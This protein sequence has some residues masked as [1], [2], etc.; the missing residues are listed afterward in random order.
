MGQRLSHCLDAAVETAASRQRCHLWGKRWRSVS[1]GAV[2]LA[3][4]LR[5]PRNAC[6]D[7]PPTKTHDHEGKIY[8][9]LSIS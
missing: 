1:W 6:T 4:S 5:D 3:D 2:V 9:F 7:I 8:D